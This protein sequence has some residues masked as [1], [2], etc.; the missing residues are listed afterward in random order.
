MP[1]SLSPPLALSPSVPLSHTRA[2][3]APRS[4]SFAHWRQETSASADSPS[5]LSS[6]YSTHEAVKAKFWPWL[7]DKILESF[8]SCSLFTWQ[9][10][11]ETSTTADPRFCSGFE[12]KQLSGT[13]PELLSSPARNMPGALKSCRPTSLCRTIP[14]PFRNHTGQSL[15][16]TGVPLSSETLTP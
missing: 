10:L 7:S 3:S 13:L 5:P 8:I 16:P 9:R 11:Q 15:D 6:E 4:L 14:E 1:L 12:K 2:L